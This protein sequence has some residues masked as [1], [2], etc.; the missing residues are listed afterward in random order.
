VV[1]T[2]GIRRAFGAAADQTCVSATKSMLGHLVNAA[3]SVELAITT[4]ALRD[5]YVPP[6]I[7]LHHPDPACD[8]DCVPLVGRSRAFEH[9][10]KVSV[11]FGGHLAAATVRRWDGPNA[12]NKQRAA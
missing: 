11:A 1:E 10:L 2:R 9:A 8:L 6:T 5:G 12:A 7:N 3:G 4:L